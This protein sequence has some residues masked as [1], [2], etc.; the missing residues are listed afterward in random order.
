MNIIIDGRQIK[1]LN[2]NKITL[3]PGNSIIGKGKTIS[4]AVSGSCLSGESF[5]GGFKIRKAL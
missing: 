4:V 5:K 2:G 1:D 3:L